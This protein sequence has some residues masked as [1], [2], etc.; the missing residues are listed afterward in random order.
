MQPFTLP[1]CLAILLLIVI[2]NL[3]GTGEAG[4]LFALPSYVFILSFI[5][6]VGYGVFEAMQHG[7][8]VQPVVR[9]PPMQAGTEALSLWLLMRAFAA[10]CT[11][12]T[13]VEAVSDGVGA[14]RKPVVPNA[15]RTLTIIVAVLAA[16][17]IGVAISR[18]Y[19]ISAPWISGSQATRA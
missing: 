16:L 17:L 12:M 6:I 2:A 9:P 18:A 15:H 8:A 19:S 13:G 5:G 14:F 1:I 3:R 4:W 11:A 7:G 10:G